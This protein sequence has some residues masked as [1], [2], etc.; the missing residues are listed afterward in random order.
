MSNQ[1]EE[2]GDYEDLLDYQQDANG[3]TVMPSANAAPDQN[4][5]K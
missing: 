3:T 1:P 5:K 4:A 2:L